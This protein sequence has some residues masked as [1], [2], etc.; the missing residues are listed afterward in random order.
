MASL[1]K[2]NK[3]NQPEAERGLLAIVRDDL[4]EQGISRPDEHDLSRSLHLIG[5]ASVE[6]VRTLQREFSGLGPL[7]GPLQDAQV[8]DVVL[9]GDGSV[10]A[11]RGEGMQPID[12]LLY[13]SDAADE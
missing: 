12:C 2:K 8:T 11:D 1:R 4:A 13:T 5:K 7:A 3:N 9:N 10:W 6:N